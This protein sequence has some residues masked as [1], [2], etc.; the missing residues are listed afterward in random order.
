VLIF[1]AAAK[2]TKDVNAEQVFQAAAVVG[3][4]GEVL[5][6]PTITLAHRTEDG[7]PRPLPASPTSS[8][9]PR[10]RHHLLRK[11]VAL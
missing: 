7:G 3:V 6:Q 1:Y 2:F 11:A 4:G 8:R 10:R 5:E 9:R